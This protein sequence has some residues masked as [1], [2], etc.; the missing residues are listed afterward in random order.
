[1][2][3]NRAITI[4]N[5]IYM[6]NTPYNT[7]P[8]SDWLSTLVHETTHVW[9]HQNGGT[10]YMGEALYAQEISGE[11]YGYE[12]DVL[13]NPPRTWFLLN[14]EQQGQLI[15]DAYLAGFFHNKQWV[16]PKMG[17]RVDLANYMIAQDIWG[18][19]KTGQGAT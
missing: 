2:N 3:N 18:Q 14:P 11:G 9:Q 13:A 19:V 7:T 6:K 15:Q 5:T 4:G 1:M 10:D 17:V 12:K 8:A 16:H